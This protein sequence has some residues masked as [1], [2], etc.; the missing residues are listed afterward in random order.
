MFQAFN[1]AIR[2]IRE[3]GTR[4]CPYKDFFE[5]KGAKDSLFRVSGLNRDERRSP[6]AYCTF[7]R[8]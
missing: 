5:H 6:S 4:E 7:Q 1:V 2:P 3:A 8:F